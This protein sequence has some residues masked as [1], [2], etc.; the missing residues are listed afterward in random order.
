MQS[1]HFW[2]FLSILYTLS[3][4]AK[5]PADLFQDEPLC[6]EAILLMLVWKVSQKV[7]L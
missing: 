3:F 4:S 7:L 5:A 6:H 2:A 1:M